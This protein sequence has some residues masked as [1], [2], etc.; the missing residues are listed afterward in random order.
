MKI[1]SPS[2][3]AFVSKCA[4]R[5]QGAINSAFLS[6]MY[7]VV[8]VMNQVLIAINPPEVLNKLPEEI[9][10]I[11]V[12]CQVTRGSQN[13]NCNVKTEEMFLLFRGKN[14]LYKKGT[15]KKKRVTRPNV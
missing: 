14:S 13:T 2:E 4:E 11:I 6:Q 5:I 7:Q 9:I 15:L 3:V 1:K 12:E 10:C 8:H